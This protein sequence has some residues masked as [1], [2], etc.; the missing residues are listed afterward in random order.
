MSAKAFMIK[1]ITQKKVDIKDLLDTIDDSYCGWR[2]RNENSDVN[3]LK[4]F[5]LQESYNVYVEETEEKKTKEKAALVKF[6]QDLKDEITF[7][8][9]LEIISDAL[10]RLDE[11]IKRFK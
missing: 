3:L 1:H 2:N 6:V 9:E 8:S 10:Y 4:F 11:A 5:N 7:G